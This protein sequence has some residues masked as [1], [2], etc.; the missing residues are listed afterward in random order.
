MCRFG[1]NLENPAQVLMEP[2]GEERS[3]FTHPLN[4]QDVQKEQRTGPITNV[5]GFADNHRA[6]MQI[7]S[8][9]RHSKREWKAQRARDREEAT[10]MAT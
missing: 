8:S 2:N 1:P 3:P 6:P 10:A 7:V 5:F 9:K 4:F